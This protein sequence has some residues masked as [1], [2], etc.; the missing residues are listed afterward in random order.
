MTEN[1][2]FD[3]NSVKSE[4]ISKVNGWIADWKGK[5]QVTVGRPKRS[6]RQNRTIHAIF[7]EIAKSWQEIGFK[8]NFGNLEATPT[9]E[10]VKELF[11]G[12]YLGGRSTTDVTTKELAESLKTLMDDVNGQLER[13]GI[14]NLIYIKSAELENLLNKKQ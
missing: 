3:D 4:I 11:K 7:G 8:V 9:P 5:G 6:Q 10:L 13:A 14:E 2:L 12:V 1:I